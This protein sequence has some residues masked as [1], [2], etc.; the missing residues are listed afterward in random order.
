MGC[1]LAFDKFL[2]AELQDGL[3]AKLLR[4]GA[5]RGGAGRGR[6]RTELLCSGRA[7]CL[8]FQPAQGFSPYIHLSMLSYMFGPK[9]QDHRSIM[10]RLPT[11]IEDMFA[12]VFGIKPW[13][14]S[15]LPV[16]RV[17]HAALSQCAWGWQA[18]GSRECLQGSLF[19]W[20]TWETSYLLE[21]S[22]PALV[23][24]SLQWRS[25]LWRPRRTGSLT[26]ETR[27]Y[28]HQM[29]HRAVVTLTPT[30][31]RVHLKV[32]P[33]LIFWPQIDV[34]TKEMLLV[35]RP[36]R[37]FLTTNH[38]STKNISRDNQDKITTCH[39]WCPNK[40]HRWQWDT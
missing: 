7:A 23:P 40:W 25:L 31:G 29:T 35:Q 2:P 38:L 33:G 13:D 26:A 37:D 27:S 34:N 20:N 17:L 9:R 14:H 18:S 24:G 28:C 16:L 32:K 11:Y 19:P 12:N 15:S 10:G 4:G 21:I 1:R 36:L 39:V 3:R 6:L 30:Q 22:A 5:G 8:D